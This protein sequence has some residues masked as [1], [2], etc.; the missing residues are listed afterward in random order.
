[1]NRHEFFVKN[2]YWV[3]PNPL[4]SNAD[5]EVYQQSMMKIMDHRYESGREPMPGRNWPNRTDSNGLV[6][7]NNA[8]WAGG[9]IRQLAL[10]SRLGKIASELL[11]VNGICMW[12]DQL[13]YKPPRS[14][15]APT[16]GNVG[17]HQD[18]NYWRVCDKPDMITA[19]VA[20]DDVSVENGAMMFV[21]GSHKWKQ[22]IKAS[23]RTLDME[24]TRGS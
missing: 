24:H 5:L 16:E 22:A 20:L 18:W 6:Q 3:E 12:H 23:D 19:W 17:W 8:W 13:L 15:D 9:A 21:S 4:F 10:N 14:A 7:I 1:M 11:Q 2:G